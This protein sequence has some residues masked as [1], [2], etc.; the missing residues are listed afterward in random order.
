MT[1]TDQMQQF[2]AVQYIPD[3]IET[4]ME[5]ALEKE[6]ADMIHKASRPVIVITEKSAAFCATASYYLAK[7]M[8]HIPVVF[9]NQ[10]AQKIFFTQRWC[11]DREFF[12]RCVGYFY[13]AAEYYP[14]CNS[15]ICSEL[16]SSDCII[17]FGHAQKDVQGE[18]DRH[19]SIVKNPN[20][21]LLKPKKLQR[22][23]W[24]H[25]NQRLCNRSIV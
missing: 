7:Q 5:H 15:S 2:M 18:L 12:N 13:K 11:E 25:W 10:A 6:Q 19:P 22:D 16:K 14:T 21:A 24:G 3:D 9:E 8:P 4:T 23:H 17:V 20:L 1:K